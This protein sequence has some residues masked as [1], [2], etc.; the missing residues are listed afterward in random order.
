M[1]FKVVN[2]FVDDQIV[3]KHETFIKP[4]VLG[5]SQLDINQYDVRLSLDI[6]DIKYDCK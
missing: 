4:L 6:I 1:S 3:F 5:L 2:G